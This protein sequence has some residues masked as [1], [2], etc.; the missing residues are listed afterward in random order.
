MITL[1]HAINFLLA[2]IGTVADNDIAGTGELKVN[3]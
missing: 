2:E 1:C 3:G